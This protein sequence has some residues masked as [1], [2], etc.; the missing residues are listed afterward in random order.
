MDSKKTNQ[1]TMKTLPKLKLQLEES[2]NMAS[3]IRQQIA[4]IELKYRLPELKK[5]YEGRFWKYKKSRGVNTVSWLY[6]YCREVIDDDT[7]N[8]DQF[9]MAEP[10]HGFK[11]NDI[12][13]FTICE[14]E[15]SKREYLKA[16]KQFQLKVTELAKCN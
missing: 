12:D 11:I 2:Q 10:H 14:I 9:E 6:S 1:T 15:I 16:F 13:Y 7:A 8:F 4:A 5:K 3:Q